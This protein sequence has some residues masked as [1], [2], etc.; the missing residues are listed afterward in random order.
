MM[1]LQLYK[2]QKKHSGCEPDGSLY[3]YEG[4][5]EVKSCVYRVPKAPHQGNCILIRS[6]PL[7][8]SVIQ[9]TIVSGICIRAMKFNPLASAM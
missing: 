9:Q 5:E 6:T 2:N 7:R 4:G 3:L 1:I 8:V